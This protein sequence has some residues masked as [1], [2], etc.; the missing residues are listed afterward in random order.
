MKL[1]DVIIPIYNAYEDVVRC[2]ESVLRHT[3]ADCRIVLIDDCSTDERI[4]AFLANLASQADARIVLLK[5]TSNTGFVGTANRGMSLSRNDVVLLNSDTIV[6]A[7]WLTKLRRCANSDTLIGTITPFSNNAEVC[8]F[9]LFCQN[10]PLEGVDIEAVNHAMEAVAIPSYPEIPTAVGFCM[11][12]RRALLDK[13]GLFDAETFGPGY[14]EENDFC[15]RAID[16][17]YRNVLC[18]DTFVAHVGSRSFSVKTEALKARNSQLLFAKYPHYLGMVQRFISED[19]IAPLR[20]RV[21]ARLAEPVQR[22]SW[23][24]S[25]ITFFTGRVR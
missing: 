2:V 13:I 11:Y 6:T 14:G 4:G 20:A 12:V 15:M 7:G 22:R 21:Q 17:G 16:A 5:N 24:A 19:P 10:N 25:I 23:L 3:A 8:S 9:P 1:I 18:D